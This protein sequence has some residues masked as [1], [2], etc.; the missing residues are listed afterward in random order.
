MKTSTY[1]IVKLFSFLTFLSC[2]HSAN[3]QSNPARTPCEE[4]AQKVEELT[5][6]CDDNACSRKAARVDAAENALADAQQKLEKAQN[7][8]ANWDAQY[9]AELDGLPYQIGQ[10]QKASAEL[11]D[12]T[13]ALINALKDLY[14]SNQGVPGHFYSAAE[15]AGKEQQY[16]EIYPGVFGERN[17]ASPGS[18]ESQ[19]AEARA[20]I[21]NRMSQSADGR[22]AR[23]AL[24]NFKAAQQAVEQ[25]SGNIEQLEARREAL[26]NQ[27]QDLISAVQRAEAALAAAERELENARTAYNDCLR[28]QDRQCQELAKMRAAKDSCDRI[29]S[30]MCPIGDQLEGYHG[31]VGSGSHQAVEEACE[32]LSD[33]EDALRRGRW[34]DAEQHAE[35]AGEWADLAESRLATEEC[36]NRLRGQVEALR[37][38]LAAAKSSQPGDYSEAEN[39]INELENLLNEAEDGMRQGDYSFAELNCTWW[40]KIPGQIRKTIRKNRSAAYRNA[41]QAAK[42]QEQAMRAEANAR[43]QEMIRLRRKT[44]CIE[45]LT[46]LEDPNGPDVDEQLMALKSELE[47]LS[48]KIDQSMDLLEKGNFSNAALEK[49]MSEVQGHLESAIGALEKYDK[50][51]GMAEQLQKVVSLFNADQ[52]AQSNSEKFGNLM[53]LV[54]DGIN[55]IADK[56]PVLQAIA[57]YFTYLVEGYTAAVEA[58]LNIAKGQMKDA[59]RGISEHRCEHI[60]SLYKSKGFA[61]TV[62]Y[63]VRESA[64]V[65]DNLTTPEQRQMANDLIREMVALR[66]KECCRKT[67][68]EITPSEQGSRILV[69]DGTFGCLSMNCDNTAVAIILPP[70]DNI[71]LTGDSMKPGL[72]AV[73]KIDKKFPWIPVGAGVVGAGVVTYIIT[74]GDDGGSTPPTTNPPVA[75]NDAVSIFCGQTSTIV[76]ALA[77][78]SGDGISIT[79]VSPPANVDVTILNGGALQVDNIADNSISFS[80]TI[81]DQEG[82]NATGTVQINVSDAQAPTITCP[83]DQSLTCG[84]DTG[85]NTTGTATA[86]DLCAGNEVNISFSDDASGLTGCSNTGTLLRIF[87]AIDPS[88]N[89]SQCTQT[90]TIINDA[91]LPNISCPPGSSVFCGENTDPDVTGTAS[92]DDNCTSTPSISF[93]DDSSGLTGCNGTGDLLRTWTATDDCGLQKSCTQTITI[94]DETPPTITCP[95]NTTVECQTSTD[96][97]V[98]GT[99]T[100]SD[101]C[102]SNIS[103]NHVDDDSG[104]TGCNGTGDLVRTWSASDECGNQQS[105]TQTISV[106]DQTPPT[107][108]CPPTITVSC[109]DPNDPT[110]TGFPTVSDNCTLTGLQPTFSDDDSGVVN[111]EGNLIRTW[112]TNDDCGNSST[113][114]QIITIQPAPCSSFST[115]IIQIN[116]PSAPS[117]NDGSIEAQINDLSHLPP[118]D[119][120]VDG[121]FNQQSLF[122]NFTIENLAVGIYQIQVFDGDG[123]PSEIISVEVDFPQTQPL[124]SVPVQLAPS[125]APDLYFYETVEHPSP[126]V[127]QSKSFVAWSS[128]TF[129]GQNTWR[130][131]FLWE[132]SLS[133]QTGTAIY[134]H[135]KNTDFHL[136]NL[137]LMTAQERLFYQNKIGNT[138]L[139]VG[140]G[141]FQKY[142]T[143]NKGGDGLAIKKPFLWGL[144]L[145]A[146]LTFEI[147]DR[148]TYAFPLTVLKNQKGSIEMNSSA[149]FYFDLTPKR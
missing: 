48:G 73:L 97:T 9:K 18:K 90:I 54:S 20:Q 122:N 104:L 43:R 116:S 32:E 59:L 106:V 103:L 6:A 131:K 11:D 127:W 71:S 82:R 29:S 84:S 136:V 146:R 91:T 140:G 108:E 77:N 10:A 134:E 38:E 101:D 86:T 130:K 27:R 137:L 107:I 87:T 45:I 70:W 125:I 26:A 128:Q 69:P 105:C 132:L 66:L 147:G 74:Q 75:T 92:A 65:M 81:T 58:I 31:E 3:A 46:L 36:I 129:A 19:E 39:E 56:F 88:G 33:A 109:T 124:W 5:R 72:T 143:I 28:Q 149:V 60:L 14:R 34:Q 98:T 95:P 79:S 123:C 93:M 94:S 25:A 40:P 16:L 139:D 42:D 13:N 118:F 53:S 1:P 144:S 145:S 115:T 76:N 2:C 21:R 78:D 142:F 148:L 4:Y 50:F 68:S 126:E 15:V 133:H 110:I 121:V 49:F 138:T 112:T 117:A 64:P 100:A 7:N 85:T 61:G 62:E 55:E 135:D 67:L 89:S 111:C 12:A 30:K 17:A 120:F 47:D 41:L 52:S 114:G 113:C 83:P 119:V 23:K 99:A 37:S 35:K 57:A 24:N 80:Y 22:A 141:L 63:F 51:K 102:G 8:L 44:D 96:P